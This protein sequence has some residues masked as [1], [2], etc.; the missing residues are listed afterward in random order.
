MSSTFDQE[1]KDS[2]VLKRWEDLHDDT[3][4]RGFSRVEWMRCVGLSFHMSLTSA[5]LW[6]LVRN[7]ASLL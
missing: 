7:V 3:L 2:E 1:I 4:S 6:N 5:H